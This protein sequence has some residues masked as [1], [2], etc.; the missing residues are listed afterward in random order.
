LQNSTK[1]YASTPHD[2]LMQGL[3]AFNRDAK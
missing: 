1:S 3:L 2:D